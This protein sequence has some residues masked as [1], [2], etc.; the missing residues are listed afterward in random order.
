MRS[1][2]PS[3]NGATA[4]SRNTKTGAALSSVPIAPNAKLFDL[5]EFELILGVQ[6]GSEAAVQPGRERAWAVTGHLY[7]ASAA[8]RA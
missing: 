5:G 1:A 6:P 2:T 4:C 7:R 8:N 3:A